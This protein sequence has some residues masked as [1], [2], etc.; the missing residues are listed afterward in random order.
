MISAISIT[1]LT[2]IRGRTRILSEFNLEVESGAILG[3]LGP[4]GSGKTTIMRSVAGLQRL[5]GGSIKVLGNPAGD[6]SLRSRISYSTQDAS[7]Y[8]DLTC[9]ENVDYF[10]ALQGRASSSTD[11]ILELVDLSRNRKQIAATLSG[12]ERA[13]LALATALV[14]RPEILILDEPTVGLD[15][16]LR[17]D[18]WSLFHRFTDEGKT[19][20]VSSHMMEEADHCDELVL[21]RDGAILAKGTPRELRTQTGVENMDAVFISLVEKP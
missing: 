15:P 9:S 4:S 11:E 19:L 1:D 6:K 18:L 17:R 20:L 7:I 13:R 2:V 12:G 14:G 21:L 16:L 5:T 10:A 3:L 8:R